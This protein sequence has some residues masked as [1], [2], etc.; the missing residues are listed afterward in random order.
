MIQ[1]P[2]AK[3]STLAKPNTLPNTPNTLAGQQFPKLLATNL[4]LD[5]PITVCKKTTLAYLLALLII[6]LAANY[7]LIM[8]YNSVNSDF[9]NM[10]GT[11][12]SG[13][14]SA[15]ALSTI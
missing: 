14:A 15:Y 2:C 13:T 4:I 9:F 1:S 11:G 12:Y 7:P 8:W 5:T 10:R 3:S 6:V